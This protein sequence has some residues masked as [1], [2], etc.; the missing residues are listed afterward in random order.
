MLLLNIPPDR[1]GRFAEEDIARLYAF[2]DALNRIF[3]DARACPLIA[4]VGLHLNEVTG[5]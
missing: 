1:T 5:E 4:E 2:R 3:T